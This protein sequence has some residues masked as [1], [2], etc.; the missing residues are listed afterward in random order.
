MFL[1]SQMS[2]H[3]SKFDECRRTVS[4]LDHDNL[5]QMHQI[6]RV[7]ARLGITPEVGELPQAPAKV[8]CQREPRE[9]QRHVA[10]VKTRRF[11]EKNENQRYQEYLRARVDTVG[12]SCELRQARTRTSE[13]QTERMK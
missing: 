5:S 3:K 6:Q 10:Q 12:K 2:K 8:D 11:W 9:W 1:E 4:K 13:P 7:R